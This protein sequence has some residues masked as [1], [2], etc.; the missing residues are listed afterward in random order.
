ILFS[1]EHYYRGTGLDAAFKEFAG[2]CLRGD[3]NGDG[4]LSVTDAVML[5]KWLLCM[6]E[7]T[8]PEAADLLPDGRIDILDLALVKHALLNQ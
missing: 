3:V 8:Q 7:M 6:G 5:Q 4:V 2:E 1:W